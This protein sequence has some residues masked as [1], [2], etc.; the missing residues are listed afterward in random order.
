MNIR[1]I[2][3]LLI[4]LVIANSIYAKTKVKINLPG[5]QNK[6]ATVWI[7]KDLNLPRERNNYPRASK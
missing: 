7:Y 1:T 3:I 5:L 4:S 2:I 6:I